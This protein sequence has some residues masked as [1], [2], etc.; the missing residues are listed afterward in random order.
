VLDRSLH[1]IQSAESPEQTTVDNDSIDSSSID[2]LPD[3]D[4]AI[5]LLIGDIFHRKRWSQQ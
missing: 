2:F 3:A 1:D 5:V 4:T